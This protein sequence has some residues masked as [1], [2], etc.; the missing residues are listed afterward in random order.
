MAKYFCADNAMRHTTNAVQIFG[1]YG[2]SKDYPL[3]R[4]MRDVKVCQIYDGTSQIHRM[5]IA[6]S[7]LK[8]FAEKA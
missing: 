8:E 5:I 7:I 4:Y 3:E 1:G 2:Y 6:R